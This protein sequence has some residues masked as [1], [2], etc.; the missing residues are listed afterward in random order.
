MNALVHLS[1]LCTEKEEKDQKKKETTTTK[2]SLGSVLTRGSRSEVHGV[3]GDLV[4][5]FGTA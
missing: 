4:G 3:I 1:T 5:D 2:I